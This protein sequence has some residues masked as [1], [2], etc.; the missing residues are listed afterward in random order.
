MSRPSRLSYTP[1][2]ILKTPLLSIGVLYSLVTYAFNSLTTEKDLKEVDEF[3]KVSPEPQAAL[4]YRETDVLTIVSF[5]LAFSF[6]GETGQ[7]QLEGKP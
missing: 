1:I 2:L 7:G 3:F 4:V 6:A 5:L